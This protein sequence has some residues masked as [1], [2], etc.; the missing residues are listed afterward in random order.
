MRQPLIEFVKI[1]YDADTLVHH[2][3]YIRIN[4]PLTG[5]CK[6]YVE[7]SEWRQRRRSKGKWF[8]A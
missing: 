8:L 1:G 7:L 5:I 2:R 4:I 6:P 3:S